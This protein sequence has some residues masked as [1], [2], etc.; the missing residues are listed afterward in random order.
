[1]CQDRERGSIGN[2]EF[3]IDTVQMDLDG[4]L[5]QPE[6]QGD[7]LVGC[8]LGKHEHDLALARGE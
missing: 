6:S 2:A 8:T 3:A 5:G 1:V 4:A 7:F